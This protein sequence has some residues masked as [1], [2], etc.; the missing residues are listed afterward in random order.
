MS[1]RLLGALLFVKAGARALYLRAA[2]LFAHQARH[3]GKKGKDRVYW[4]CF[5]DRHCAHLSVGESI[6]GLFW[7]NVIPMI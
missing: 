5:R 4:K 6:I 7:A 2:R 3:Q 1:A